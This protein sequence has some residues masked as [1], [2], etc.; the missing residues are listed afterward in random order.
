MLYFRHESF[1]VFTSSSIRNYLVLDASHHRN[2]AHGLLFHRHHVLSA[3]A[4]ASKQSDRLN[5][6]CPAARQRG[7]CSSDTLVAVGCTSRMSCHQC[8][9]SSSAIDRHP[10]APASATSRACRRASTASVD[11]HWL[12]CDVPHDRNCHKFLCLSVA[13]SPWRV[14]QFCLREF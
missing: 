4:A 9:Y 8:V 14:E 7:R 3:A 6:L 13:D 10:D 2:R 12:R 11:R 5:D 1:C